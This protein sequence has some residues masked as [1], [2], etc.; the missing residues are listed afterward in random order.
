MMNLYVGWEQSNRTN[1]SVL[2]FTLLAQSKDSSG[3]YGMFAC[4]P[5]IRDT[6]QFIGEIDIKESEK[7]NRNWKG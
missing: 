7:F 1:P 5:C 4:S 2:T 3:P 6:Y